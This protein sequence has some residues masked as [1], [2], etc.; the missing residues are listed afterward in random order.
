MLIDHRTGSAAESFF[1]NARQ[2]NG[3]IALG[4]NTIGGLTYGNCCFEDRLVHSGAHLRFGYHKWRADI[5]QPFREGA[6]Y[7]PDYWLDDFDAYEAVK[8]IEKLHNAK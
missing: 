3:V 8:R 4:E 2:I 1:E 6:G 7:F 5:T